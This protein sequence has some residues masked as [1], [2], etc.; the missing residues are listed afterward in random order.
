MREIGGSMKVN[1]GKNFVRARGKRKKM[2]L[3][4]LHEASLA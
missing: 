4:A 3:L 2:K 1:E